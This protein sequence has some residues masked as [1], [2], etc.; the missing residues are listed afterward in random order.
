MPDETNK[1]EGIYDLGI[2]LS[3]ISC[4]DK[5]IPTYNMLVIGGLSISGK[6]LPS[7][8]IF[9]AI[10]SA[11][12]ENISVLVCSTEDVK[13][14]PDGILHNLN[15]FGINI[16]DGEY[17][18]DI[19]PL[20]KN[21][22]INQ[23]T[24]ILPK[25][26]RPAYTT[27]RTVRKINLELMHPITRSLYIGLCGGHNTIIESRSIS[28]FKK[29]YKSLC[30]YTQHMFFGK[31]MYDAYTYK[32]RDTEQTRSTLYIENVKESFFLQKKDY[33]DG[34]CVIGTYTSCPCGYQ[35]SFF[36]T[37]TEDRKCICSKRSLIH[38]KRYIEDMYFAAFHIQEHEHTHQTE[39]QIL[40]Q[41]EIDIL[42]PQIDILRRI[43]FFRY[44]HNQNMSEKDIFFWGNHVYMNKHIVTENPIKL[45]D[46]DAYIIWL[47][48]KQDIR[49]IGV[50][51]TIQDI[52]NF[53]KH[54]EEIVINNVDDY[55]QYQKE[56]P[57]ISK[58]ALLLALSYIPK[59]DF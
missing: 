25:E 3:C 27:S 11:Y 23:N 32:L 18:Q 2:A 21:H 13:Q 52:L 20:I 30:D 33:Q 7:E 49:A 14:I 42:H 37:K 50:S 58:Q 55:V 28:L 48:S 38:H 54:T 57:T 17:I 43:Q 22:N 45:L 26:T 10:Y 12:K 41:N 29:T 53:E 59:M 4:I 24:K 40:S 51:Q 6:I 35:Y 5:H 31:R 15:V 19:V 8:R 39:S 44:A 1:R 47:Q 16:I 46:E 56:K 36:T 34:G 9:Q